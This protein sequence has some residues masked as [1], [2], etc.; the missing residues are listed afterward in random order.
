M[1]VTVIVPRSV[2]DRARARRARAQ[3]VLAA[4]SEVF[5]LVASL[6]TPMP[7]ARDEDALTIRRAWLRASA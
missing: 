1:A 6:F 7:P 3:E 5:E 4:F 2:A